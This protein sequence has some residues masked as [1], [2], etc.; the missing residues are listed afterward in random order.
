MTDISI[1]PGASVPGDYL[2]RTVLPNRTHFPSTPSQLFAEFEMEP[3]GL[4]I[5]TAGFLELEFVDLHRGQV[6][7]ELRK[8]FVDRKN[9]KLDLS[10]FM[11]KVKM[12]LPDGSLELGQ[13]YG[14]VLRD[15]LVEFWQTFRSNCIA[16]DTLSVPVVC[17][18]MQEDEW[19]AIAKVLV[20]G[21]KQEHYIPTFPKFCVHQLVFWNC[22]K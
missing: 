16:G 1:N 19:E 13:D 10:N 9:M 15:A 2:Q 20:I 3:S 5:S 8:Y 6:F 21:Y 17:V 18:D 4:W 7:Q 14:G 11:L 22:A 12:V